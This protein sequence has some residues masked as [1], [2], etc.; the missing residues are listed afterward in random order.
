[1]TKDNID[2]FLNTL[3]PSLNSGKLKRVVFASSAAV[4][5][6]IESPFKESDVPNPQDIYGISKLANES[7]L[8]VMQSQ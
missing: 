2:V 1:M 3:V 8:K 6:S 4:Y 7:F 5:G